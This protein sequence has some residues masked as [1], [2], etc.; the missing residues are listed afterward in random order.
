MDL[1]DLIGTARAALEGLPED[2]NPFLVL[3]ALLDYAPTD[4]G[5]R[6]IAE[7]IITASDEEDGFQL[8]A[9]FYKNGLL[10]PSKLPAKFRGL[11]YQRP[12]R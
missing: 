4:K 10:L 8:L 2:Q 1:N 9:D 5:R 11:S 12:V 3:N 7:D 6:Q